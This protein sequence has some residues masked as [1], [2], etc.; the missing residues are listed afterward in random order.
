MSARWILFALLFGVCLLFRDLLE[1]H[2]ASHVLVQ[3]PLLA[4][5]GA[6]WVGKKRAS[7]SEW[8]QGGIA[9]LLVALTG[10]IFW[11]LP[12]SIDA[13][14]TSPFMEAFKFISLPLFV[15]AALRMGWNAA[16]DLLRG[17]L[18]AQT[19]SMLGVAAFL[20]THA[21]VRLCNAYLVSEQEELGYGFL[22]AAIVLALY[23]ALPLFISK[24][25]NTNLLAER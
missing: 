1:A 10:I 17:F 22:I 2:P 11:M 25:S 19:L 13:A 18:K 6:L 9:S 5:A 23:W 15:G 24:H 3:L 12:R 8:N 4:L 20:Y 14:L 16:P 7:T 21:P